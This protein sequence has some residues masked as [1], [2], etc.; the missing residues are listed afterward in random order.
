MWHKCLCGQ[1]QSIGFE[2]KMAPSTFPRLV[3]H[4][5]ARVREQVAR[6]IREWMDFEI[7]LDG[8]T[9]KLERIYQLVG[10]LLASWLAQRYDVWIYP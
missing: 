2:I 3:E 6:Q 9:W 1:A 5:N 4:K 7:F 10:R 8:I